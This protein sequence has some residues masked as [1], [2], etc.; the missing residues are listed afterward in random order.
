M[1]IAVTCPTCAWIGETKDELAGQP[2]PCPQCAAPIREGTPSPP[3]AETAGPAPTEVAPVAAPMSH[4]ALPTVAAAGPLS[5]AE[6]SALVGGTISPVRTT[7]AYRL[8][9]A[10][11]GVMMVLLPLVSITWSGSFRTPQ[12]AP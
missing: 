1:S 7:L 9:L 5:A 4:T 2:L 11:V 8:S 3:A 6:A 12:P 10:L